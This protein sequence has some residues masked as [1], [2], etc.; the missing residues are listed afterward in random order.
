MKTVAVLGVAGSGKTQFITDM[1][2]KEKNVL[3]LSHTVTAV[4]VLRRRWRPIYST[5]VI[6]TIHGFTAKK[7]RARKF[8]NPETFLKIGRDIAGKPVFIK[9]KDESLY[10]DFVMIRSNMDPVDKYMSMLCMK[11]GLMADTVRKIFKKWY[12]IIREAPDYTGCLELYLELGDEYNHYV[13]VLVIDE[14]QDLSKLQR[15]VVKKIYGN[16]RILAGDPN[17]CI[18]KFLGGNEKFYEELDVD[19]IIVLKKSHRVKKGVMKWAELVL[20]RGGIYYDYEA[21][22]LEGGSMH[23]IYYP[24]I[25]LILELSDRYKSVLV[26]FPTKYEL[27]AFV[28]YLNIKGYSC[29]SLVSAKFENS[30]ILSAIEKLRRGMTL[31]YKE[32]KILGKAIKGDKSKPYANSIGTLRE[33]VNL[34]PKPFYSIDELSLTKE[35][36]EFIVKAF[37]ERLTSVFN[38]EFHSFLG[39][40]NILPNVY[41]STIHAAKGMEADAVVLDATLHRKYSPLEED[42]RKIIYVGLTRSNDVVYM[43]FPQ[44]HAIHFFGSEGAIEFKRT[45]EGRKCFS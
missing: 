25:D 13:D 15:E 28:K 35:E 44:E 40:Q 6:D 19:D 29:P 37:D 10:D 3:A 11:Y 9:G 36:R 42:Q 26:L 8:S 31:D 7:I 39:S 4:E 1:I 23:K 34:V 18:Y 32:A 38:K 5:Q 21:E 24:K 27:R 12:E 22:Y 43:K 14:C 20:R 17:Q 2:K 45:K 30:I 16:K 33:Y 41:V